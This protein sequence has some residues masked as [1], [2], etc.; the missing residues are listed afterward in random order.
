MR[1]FRKRIMVFYVLLSIVMM[2]L[3]GR[4]VYIQVFWS[5]ALTAEAKAQQNKKIPIPAERGSILDRNEIGR[6]SCRERV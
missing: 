4:L 6:A 1:K 2:A 5:D 3:I